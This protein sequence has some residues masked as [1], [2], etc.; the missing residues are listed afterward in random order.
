MYTIRSLMPWEAWKLKA[1]LLRL[2]DD[3]RRLR[4]GYRISD[5]AIEA[6]VS[7]INWLNERVLVASD[8]EGHVIGAVHV[9]R[10]GSRDAEFAF[11]VERNYRQRGI[12]GALCQRALLWARNRGFRRAFTYCAAQNMA[13]RRLALACGMRVSCTGGD[14]E[15]NL[16]L[17]PASLSTWLSEMLGESWALSSLFLAA[18]RRS[19]SLLPTGGAGVVG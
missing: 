4:F 2:D 9:A 17:A 3:D 12:G 18:Q 1:H 8:E 10:L 6:F 5:A 13:M 11:S 19:L 16:S 15:G 14:C 7:R